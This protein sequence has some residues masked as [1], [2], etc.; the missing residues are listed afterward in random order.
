[1]TDNGRREEVLDFEDG[2]A[3][4]AGGAE[5][6]IDRGNEW[7]V[8]PLKLAH[9]TGKPS[10]RQID[11]H[12]R[13]HRPFQSWC[14]WCVLG[15]GRVVRIHSDQCQFGAEVMSGRTRGSQ[16]KKPRVM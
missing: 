3:E 7:D 13:A 15:R 2:L 1:M 12:H 6:E 14:R 9:N 11:E 16:I 5:L 4:G 10:E 8:E